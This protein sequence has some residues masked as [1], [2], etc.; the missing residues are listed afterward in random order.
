MHKRSDSVV[1]REVF[2]NVV[3]GVNNKDDSHATTVSPPTLTSILIGKG[4]IPDAFVMSGT[5]IRPRSEE[6]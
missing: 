4:E 3:S 6:V 5:A 1:D 2:G